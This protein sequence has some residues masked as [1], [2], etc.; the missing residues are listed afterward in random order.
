MSVNGDHV[1]ALHGAGD[2]TAGDATAGGTTGAKTSGVRVARQGVRAT[3]TDDGPAGAL[4]LA[5]DEPLQVN[6]LPRV[7][8][9]LQR[10]CR[11]ARRDLSCCGV[12][13]SVVSGTGELVNFVGSSRTCVWV[14]ELQFSL[15]EGPSLAAFAARRPVFVP[16]LIEAAT[17]MWPEYA[18]AAHG[19]GLRAVFAFPL[20]VGVAWLGALNVY[21]AEPGALSARAQDRALTYADLAAQMIVDAHEDTREMAAPDVTRGQSVLHRFA[22]YIPKRPPSAYC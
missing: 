19:E 14:E 2:T 3:P 18:P 21:Q 10:L 8:G 7:M 9:R 1:S 17:T 20:Q 5:A 13:I 12:G 11:A 16:N 15:G 6:D 4:N 22:A